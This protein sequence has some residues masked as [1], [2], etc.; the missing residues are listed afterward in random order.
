MKEIFLHKDWELINPLTKERIPAKVPGS[1][2]TDLLAAGKIDDPFYRDNENTLMHIGE[3]H[4]LYETRFNAAPDILKSRVLF[5]RMYGLDTLAEI[6]LNDQ[7][8]G[9]TRNMYCTVEYD[10]HTILVAGENRLSVLFQSTFPR[11]KKRQAER[12][13][14]NGGGPLVIKGASQI[15]KS[16]CNYGWDWGPRCVTCGIWQPVSL[17]YGEE[18]ISEIKVRQQHFKNLVLLQVTAGSKTGNADL[19]K[20]A[21]FDGEKQIAE[22]TALPA[23]KTALLKLKIANPKLWWPAGEGKAHLYRLE[24]SAFSAGKILDLRTQRIGLRTIKLDQKKDKWGTSFV[25]TV[26]GKKIFCKGADWIPADVFYP[27]VENSKYRF[28]LESAILANMNM[29]RVWGGGIY[30]NDIF[31]NLCDELGIMVWQD[32]MFACA[33]YPSDREYISDIKQ[34]IADNVKRLRHHASLALWCGNNE[35]EMIKNFLSK[36][37]EDGKMTENE[38]KKLFHEMIPQTLKIYDDETAYWP[39]ISR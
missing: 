35:I 2:H 27:R 22:C 1:V 38:Y 12:R 32:F 25:F 39:S 30:E 15:R 17:I 28:L 20:A 33:A 18:F 37:P 5:L 14:A 8:L 4:W 13:F 21:L 34:E 16:P 29:I 6:R 23:G 7:L 9:K 3:Q 36:K 31:Y 19:I 10:V 26:N 24:V 11:I